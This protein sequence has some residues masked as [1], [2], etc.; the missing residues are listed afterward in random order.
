MS[1]EIEQ[2]KPRPP[3]QEPATFDSLTQKENLEK[4]V[5]GIHTP[6]ELKAAQIA[7]LYQQTGSLPDTVK[8]LDMPYRDAWRIFNSPLYSRYAFVLKHNITAEQVAA[9]GANAARMW[10][11]AND[12]VFGSSTTRTANLKHLAQIKGLMGSDE[13][14]AQSGTA[15]INLNITPPN[16]K[17]A[18]VIEAE[19]GEADE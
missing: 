11:E 13:K 19:I 9:G 16:E 2:H 10:E 8:L 14:E 6:E 18:H 5:G 3:S 7:F 4:L 17:D 1:E 12:Y 15:T